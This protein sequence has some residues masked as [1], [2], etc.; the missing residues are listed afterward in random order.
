[1]S[2]ACLSSVQVEGEKKG[3]LKLIVL[4]HMQSIHQ[5]V[6]VCPHEE[7]TEMLENFDIVVAGV[8]QFH[9]RDGE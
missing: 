5:I 4:L 2:K 9:V 8:F 3:Y 7:D 1:M 6:P